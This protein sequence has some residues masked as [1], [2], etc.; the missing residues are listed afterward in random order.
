LG[1]AEDVSHVEVESQAVLDQALGDY[2]S[3]PGEIL[4]YL[5]LE[6]LHVAGVVELG[7][8]G[9]A[10]PQDHLAPSWGSHSLLVMSVLRTR[11][12]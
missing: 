9:E 5:L 6:A 4:R 2:V 11:R 7:G 8:I 3:I 1:V 12:I 10:G